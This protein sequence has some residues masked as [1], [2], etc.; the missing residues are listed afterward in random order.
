M[1]KTSPNDPGIK[2]KN[3]K[4]NHFFIKSHIKV[5]IS[6]KMTILT[7]LQHLKPIKTDRKSIVDQDSLN[8][9]SVAPLRC[10][11]MPKQGPRCV[12]KKKNQKRNTNGGGAGC[13]APPVRVTFLIFFITNKR[14]FKKKEKIKNVTRTGGRAMSLLDGRA[15][16]RSCYVFDFFFF[17]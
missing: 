1:P 10:P 15:P 2:I 11:F 14:S 5:I 6:S 7:L 16:P 3:R 17:L 13:G 4:K 9:T 8:I 12:K